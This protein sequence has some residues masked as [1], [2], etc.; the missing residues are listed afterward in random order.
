MSKNEQIKGHAE[1]VGCP[2]SGKKNE[3]QM[4]AKKRGGGNHS[5]LI[6]FSIILILLMS[7]Y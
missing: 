6:R 1:G 2:S 7:G 3:F 5:A 4:K